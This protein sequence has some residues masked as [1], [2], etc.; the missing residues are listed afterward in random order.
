MRINVNVYKCKYPYVH[1]HRHFGSTL[2]YCGGILGCFD[3][4]LDYFGGVL[5]YF[6]YFGTAFR[7]VWLCFCFGV[8]FV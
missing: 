2:V 3:N 5:G 6:G 1:T 4:T 8:H 7:A